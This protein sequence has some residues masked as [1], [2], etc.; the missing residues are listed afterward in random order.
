MDI[1]AIFVQRISQWVLSLWKS[2]L[3]IL[4]FSHLSCIVQSIDSWAESVTLRNLESTVTISPLANAPAVSACW[5]AWG[6]NWCVLP[7]C[8]FVTRAPLIADSPVWTRCLAPESLVALVFWERPFR[9]IWI[10]IYRIPW[11]I[12]LLR[13]RCGCFLLDWTSYSIRVKFLW[14]T[15]NAF[16][17]LCARKVSSLSMIAAIPTWRQTMLSCLYPARKAHPA[18]PLCPR[19]NHH[20]AIVS[21]VV[22]FVDDEFVRCNEGVCWKTTT[23]MTFIILQIL[24]QCVNLPLSKSKISSN[25]GASRVAQRPF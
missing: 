15:R 14:E 20:G 18:N 2:V 6:P 22:K 5:G 8:E 9:S 11:R 12:L 25:I 19:R 10:R 17:V 1:L 7:I 16:R 13:W 3:P 4:R 23:A 21:G 24:Q